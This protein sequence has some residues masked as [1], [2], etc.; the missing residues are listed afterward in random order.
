MQ[1]VLNFY[2]GDWDTNIDG[3]MYYLNTSYLSKKRVYFIFPKGHDANLLVIEALKNITFSQHPHLIQAETKVYMDMRFF[4]FS[5]PREYA[6]VCR[7]MAAHY[8]LEAS[9]KSQTAFNLTPGI[10][11][12]GVTIPKSENIIVIRGPYSPEML[13]KEKIALEELGRTLDALDLD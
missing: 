5:I 1:S 4:S 12:Y 13:L 10:Q 11:H 2:M 6:S 9:H 3:P 8:N 7:T